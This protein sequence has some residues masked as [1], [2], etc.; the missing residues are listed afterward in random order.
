MIWMYLD[1]YKK[2]SES[3]LNNY[4]PKEN[5][6]FTKVVCLNTNTLF[7]KI[8]DASDWCN[9]KTTTGI[10]NCCTG[11][12]HTSGKHPETGEPLKWMYFKDYI[13]IFDEST[14]SLLNEMSA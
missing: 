1:E 7:Q 6:A 13:E 10:V 2:M 4:I 3:D 8:K 12:F 11:K 5:K 9:S 14:L